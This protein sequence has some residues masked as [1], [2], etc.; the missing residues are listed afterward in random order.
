[1]RFYFNRKKFLQQKLTGNAVIDELIKGLD[2]INKCDGKEC[3]RD[4]KG[5][6]FFVGNQEIIIRRPW[7]DIKI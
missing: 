2:W 3:I 6:Y 4:K 7:L 5:K 1:M